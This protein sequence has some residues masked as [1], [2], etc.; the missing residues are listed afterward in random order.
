[1]T[2]DYFKYWGKAKPSQNS[3]SQWHLLPFH[4]LDVAAVGVAYLR[5]APSF[6][7][8]FE[9]S[10]GLR[11]DALTNWVAFWLSLHDLG[12]FSA[13]FQQQR[14][15]I[16]EALRGPT[17]SRD[18]SVRHDSLGMLFWREVLIDRSNQEEWFGPDSEALSDGLIWWARSVTGHHGQ[19]PDEQLSS[20]PAFFDVRQDA[21]AIDQFVQVVR[22][23]FLANID[24]SAGCFADPRAFEKSSKVLSWW[25]A[26]LSVLADWVGSNTEYFPYQEGEEALPGYWAR[27]QGMAEAALKPLGVLPPHSQPEQPFSKLF[28]YIPTASPLQAWASEVHLQQGPQIYLLEDVTGAGKTEA[29]MTLAHRLMSQGH[30]DGFFIGLPTMATANAMYGRMMG[31]YGQLFEGEA[32]L[33]LAHAQRDLV[34]MFAESVLLP[35]QVEHDHA[36]A[37]QTATAQ[38][39]A[40]LADH[41]KRA[42]LAPAG[43]GTIDQALL[44]VLQSKHQS[45]RLLGLFRKVLIVDEVHA[46]DAYMQGVL[47]RLLQFHAKVGGSAILLSATLPQRM[48]QALLAA[49]ARGTGDVVPA[50]QEDAYPLVTSW[51][52]SRADSLFE[53]PLATR[54]DVR[55][56]LSIRSLSSVDEVVSG[57]NEALS[58]GRCVCWM[59]NTVADVLEAYARFAGILPADQITVFH[60]RFALQDRLAIEQKVLNH[61]GKHST[62][63]LRRGRLVIASQVAEQSLDADWDLVVSDLAPIDRLIQRAGRLQRHPRDVQGA[64][65]TDPTAKDQRTPSCLWVLGPAWSEQP[66]VGWFK[67]AFPASAKVYPHHGQLWLTGRCLRAGALTMPDDARPIIESV[68]GA[69]VEF[70]VGLEAVANQV[71]GEDMG[72]ASLAQRNT[73]KL[74]QGYCRSVADWL[75]EAKTPSRVGEPSTNVL[76][77]KW[78]DGQLLPWVDH[79]VTKHAWAYSTV[80]VPER[81]IGATAKPNDPSFEY[82]LARVTEALPDQGRW[83]VLLPLAL[84][85]DG[86]WAGAAMAQWGK[87]QVVRQ[88]AYDTQF[89]LKPTAF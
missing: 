86:R 69:D 39:S 22:R 67:D 30:A 12:K 9:Q 7:A 77:A 11:G 23:L 3:E 63:E 24:F 29:A 74:E 38:C 42:L 49:Y 80:R 15:D 71:E 68:F 14:R 2:A 28:P 88:W 46:C 13:S 25:L 72:E 54:D 56:T 4:C 73:V 76:L 55:R 26:G 84:L 33:A 52:P 51:S 6:R 45:L 85:P 31:F 1:M 89:G 43:V 20:I 59:R 66:C 75:S 60:A 78:V 65:L 41:N 19:P 50:L 10:T 32:S 81:L 62:P 82:E 27:A 17:V 79:D 44:A 58:E 70:P 53:T 48:K 83:S 61:F 87:R 18:Y 35:G 36:Q 16:S 34:A 57:I 8:L 40:W 47:E 21:Q 37:D 5:K 64:R